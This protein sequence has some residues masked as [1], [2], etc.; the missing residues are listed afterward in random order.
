MEN[1][2]FG[3][4]GKIVHDLDKFDKWISKKMNGNVFLKKNRKKFINLI[5][6]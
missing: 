2:Y 3:N 5:E 4:H 1:Y 6:Y